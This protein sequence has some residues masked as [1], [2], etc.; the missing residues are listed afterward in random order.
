MGE[1]EAEQEVNLF[2]CSVYVLTRNIPTGGQSR[3]TVRS[4]QSMASLSLSSNNVGQDKT[5]LL[6]CIR[7]KNLLYFITGL[8]FVIEL[9]KFREWMERNT[10]PLV[11][12]M[13]NQTYFICFKYL[14][15][16][17]LYLHFRHNHMASSE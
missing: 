16:V 17:Q 4:I 6:N 11:S 7:K 13:F 1:G 8:C 2:C 14:P 15:G 9:L 10:N 3:V 5:V 12:K